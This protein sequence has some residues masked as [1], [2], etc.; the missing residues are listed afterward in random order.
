MTN[1]NRQEE[2]IKH[3]FDSILI[4]VAMA[5]DTGACCDADRCAKY[6]GEFLPQFV[7]LMGLEDCH[8]LEQMEH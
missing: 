4:K 2:A 8:Y 7:Q 3:T 1:R 6:V 5:L